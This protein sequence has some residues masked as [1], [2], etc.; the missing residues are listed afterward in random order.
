MDV[1]RK[2]GSNVGWYY[3]EAR[4]G[5]GDYWPDARHS[6]SLN[7]LYID[8]HAAPMK[9]SPQM[10]IAYG[11]AWTETIYGRLGYWGEKWGY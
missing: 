10:A 8:G 7:I 6:S 3:V 11:V 4:P 2:V 5:N 9:V 1:I